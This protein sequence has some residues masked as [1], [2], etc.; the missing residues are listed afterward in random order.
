MIPRH[1][2]KIKSFLAMD[3]VE[4]LERRR[5]AGRPTISFSLG[6]PDVQPPESVRRA[7][8]HALEQ[9]FTKYTSTQGLPELREAISADYKRKYD[10]TVDPNRILVTGGT[11]PALLLVFSVL[12][13]PGDNA[14]VSNPHYPCYPAFVEYLKAKPNYVEVFEEDGFQYRPEEIEKKIGPKTKAIL[15]NS[16]SNPTGTLLPDASMEAI[17]ALADK[18]R[19]IVSDEIYHNLVYE[20]RERSILEFTD[21]AFVLNGFSKSY[22]M[23]GYRL[24]YVIAPKPFVRTM[25]ILH[26][27]FYISANSFVQ[28]AGVAALQEGE[29]YLRKIRQIFDERRKVMLEGVEKLGFKVAVRP[30]GAFYV[31]ANVKHLTNDSHAFALDLL[32]QTDVGVT[33]GIDFGSGGEGY[34]RFSYATSVEKIREGLE[35][36][37]RYLRG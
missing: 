9:D 2:Q 1:I 15:V 33:P 32:E 31:F 24:G 36:I 4:K 19:W 21:N 22:A 23:T 7:C 27:N 6:E 20:G 10:V 30:T 3:I 5:A 26:Q 35:R 12:L 28:K 37:E 14:I 13:G 18:N 25:Q 34:L 17:A 16:P 29:K 11:S 8:M